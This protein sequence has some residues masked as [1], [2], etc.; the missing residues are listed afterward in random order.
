MERPRRHI[1]IEEGS[2]HIHSLC[3]LEISGKVLESEVEYCTVCDSQHIQ[4]V[5][6]K[7]EPTEKHITHRYLVSFSEM[8]F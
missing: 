1:Q 7:K 4:R 5:C 3:T 2:G 6:E 8:H